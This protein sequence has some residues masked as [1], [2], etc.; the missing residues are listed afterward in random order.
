MSLSLDPAL[1]LDALRL[2]RQARVDLTVPLVEGALSPGLKIRPG[3][4]LRVELQVAE[5]QLDFEA[6]RFELLPALDGP[7][8]TGVKGLRFDD[9]HRLTLR[10]AGLPDVKLG[11]PLPARLDELAG[12]LKDGGPELLGV[13][14]FGIRLGSVRRQTVASFAPTPTELLNG[15]DRPGAPLLEQARLSVTDVELGEGLLTLAG[16]GRVRVGPDAGGGLEAGDGQ[17][18]LWADIHYCDLQLKHDPW[19]LRDGAGRGRLCVEASWTADGVTARARLEDLAL[20]AGPGRLA[21]HEGDFLAL[22]SFA[23]SGGTVELEWTLGQ[24]ALLHAEL[25]DAEGT[26]REGRVSL[27]LDGQPAVVEVED[28]SWRGSLRVGPEDLALCGQV[29]L[30][31]RVP[32]FRP[33]ADAV[34]LDIYDCV[35]TGDAD[36]QVDLR[37]GVALRGRRLLGR[38]RIRE[39]AVRGWLDHVEIDVEDG[40][41]AELSISLLTLGPDGT[42][43]VEG[44]GEL[45]LRLCHMEVRD[46]RAR[47][48][49]N[50]A[51]AKGWA[52]VRLHTAEGVV[53]SDARMQLGAA[54]WSFEARTPAGYATRLDGDFGMQLGQGTVD[55]EQT[56]CLLDPLRDGTVAGEVHRGHLELPGGE[57]IRLRRG[58]RLQLQIDRGRLGAAVGAELSG[59]LRL[60]ARLEADADL[61]AALRL[62]GL[63]VGELRADEH[64]LT[65]DLAGLK[66]DERGGFRL[67]NVR[68]G[69]VS[70][71]ELVAGRLTLDELR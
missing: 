28:S 39:A 7:L 45:D 38:T 31:A 60:E 44:E 30:N 17:A 8:F 26:L 9:D 68:V 71:M 61:L 10:I 21:P 59:A 51:T 63:E 66:L 1:L 25:P 53:L 34:S 35:L 46:E 47:L 13:R 14:L 16:L 2:V 20:E 62:A 37:R 22:H 32:E 48:E 15:P 58:S 27:L 3:T 36:L 64:H 18:R 5:G 55:V 56:A 33:R 4:V 24:P 54:H 52:G 49:A 50:G 12:W 11:P 67:F 23:T 40:S 6:A 65:V 69:V 57:R 42:L 70:T 43:R 41:R 19:E 29:T